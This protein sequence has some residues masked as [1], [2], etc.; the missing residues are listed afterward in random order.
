VTE[1]ALRLVRSGCPNCRFEMSG[2]VPDERTPFAITVQLCDDH[3]ELADR[4]ETESADAEA[5]E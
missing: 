2:L 4:V 1:D 5:P 3:A